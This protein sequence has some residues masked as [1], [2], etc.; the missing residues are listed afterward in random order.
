MTKPD[1]M[2]D[3]SVVYLEAPSFE[4]AKQQVKLADN[5]VAT[6]EVK[7]EELNAGET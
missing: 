2:H 6:F 5:Q 7:E 4:A 3:V 1:M